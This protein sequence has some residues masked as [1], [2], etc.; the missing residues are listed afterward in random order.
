MIINTYVSYSNNSCEINL[1]E[2]CEKELIDWTKLA[3]CDTTE[4]DSDLGKMGA[5]LQH[6]TVGLL[7]RVANN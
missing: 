1:L 3:S 4:T 7:R 6:K 5:E 2:C